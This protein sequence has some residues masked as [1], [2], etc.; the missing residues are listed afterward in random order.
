MNP[1][2]TEIAYVLD[3]SGSMEAIA[4]DA[5]GG[6]N[7]FLHEQQQLPG[8][9]RFTLILFDHEYLTP[10]NAVDIHRVPPLTPHTYTPRGTTALHD[11]VG[12]TIDALG[13]RLAATPETE[14]PAKVI[15]GILTDGLEN[16]STDYSAAKVAQ[17]IRH[18]R[19][20]YAWEFVFLAANQD[21]V[22]AAGKLAIRAEDAIQFDATGEG[23]REAHMR[24]SSS[25]RQRR[26]RA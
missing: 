15:V 16:A 4:S 26:S 24:L 25:M 13:A 6:F 19:E 14:R 23:V 18:Q 9:V 22:A 2:L 8:A 3:R 17:M 11:A 12:R 1:D 7:A 10:Y 21:A 20:K 5:I